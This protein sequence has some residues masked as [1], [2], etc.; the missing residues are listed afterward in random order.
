MNYIPSN[1][2]GFLHGSGD[3]G[4]GLVYHDSAVL[5]AA[6][7][8]ADSV[9]PCRVAGGT[10]VHR[11]TIK[12]PD[13]DTNATPTLAAKIGFTPSDGSAQPAGADVAVSAAAAFGQSAGTISFDVF[14]PYL[15]EQDSYL[16]ITVTT[17]PATGATGTVYA[18]VEGEAI[19]IK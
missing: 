11:V 4:N 13:L 15:V 18:K 9:R 1:I 12:V 16:D 17:A 14:P 10:K 2:L 3:D 7:L 6:L 5:T 19:G 8:L